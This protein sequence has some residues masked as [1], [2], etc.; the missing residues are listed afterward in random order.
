MYLGFMI[1]QA[2]WRNAIDE[3]W[4]SET[5]TRFVNGVQKNGLKLRSD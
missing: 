5:Q 4:N 1:T 3:R 2:Y